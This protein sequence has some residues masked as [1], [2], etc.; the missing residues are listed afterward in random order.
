MNDDIN[1]LFCQMLSLTS[2]GRIFQID[3]GQS[4][5][6]TRKHMCKG[7]EASECLACL[8]NEEF[9]YLGL[10][11]RPCAVMRVW[12]ETGETDK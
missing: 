6:G 4:A 8:G 1:H 10:Q 12:L 3:R 2:V 7:M 11:A 9:V 5:T